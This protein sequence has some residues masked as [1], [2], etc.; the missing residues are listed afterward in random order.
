VFYT[1][2]KLAVFIDGR[3]LAAATKSLDMQ[4]DFGKFR[5]EFARRGKMV[6]ATYYTMIDD[7]AEYTGVRKVVDWLDYNGFA[8][9]TKALKRRT[10]ES[11]GVRLSGN[12]KVEM[13]IDLA[14]LSPRIDHVVLVSGDA[15]LAPAVEM[16]KRKGVRVSLLSTRK[17][18]SNIVSDDLRRA[19][20]NFIDLADLRS[21]VER[22][23]ELRE[24]S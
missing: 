16:L 13:V 15:D 4:I 11:G 18:D 1:S 22:K 14:E 6:R 21:S 10:D 24:A 12:M 7:E 17:G 9:K 20:D 19:A 5:D 2:D 23:Y 3:S 8:I